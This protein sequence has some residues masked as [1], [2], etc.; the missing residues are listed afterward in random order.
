M[1]GIHEMSAVRVDDDAPVHVTRNTRA[2]LTFSEPRWLRVAALFAAAAV[3]SFGAVGL[4]L[5]LLGAYRPVLAFPLGSVAWIALLI[6]AW[7]Y[8]VEVSP[9]ATID[10]TPVA[11]VSH[12]AAVV[13]VLAILTITAWNAAQPSQHVLIT[14]DPGGYM[15]EGRWLARHG[16]LD[17]HPRVE[18]FA[19]EPELSY[20]SF[21]VYMMSDGTLQYQF[22]HLLPAVLAQTYA[23]GG[24]RLMFRA[25]ALLGGSAMLAFFVLAW[26]LLRR[27]WFAVGATVTLALLLPQVWFS[28]DSYSEI[29]SQVLLFTGLWLVTNDRILPAPRA[30]FAA[31]LFVGGLQMVRIDAMAFLVGAPVLLAVVWLTRAREQAAGN[32]DAARRIGAFVLGI[33]PGATLGIWDVTRHSGQYYRHLSSQMNG[34]IAATAG[35]A[36]V[37]LAV[38]ALWQRLGSTVRRIPTRFVAVSAGAGVAVIGLF[39]WAFRPSLQDTRGEVLGAIKALELR[40]HVGGDGT[41]RYYERSLTWMQWYLGWPTLAFAIAGAGLL[42]AALL[43]GRRPRALAATALLAP[44]SLLY[45]WKASAAPDHIWVARRFLT[46]AFPA[47]VLLAFGVAAFLFTRTGRAPS[48]I[49]AKVVAVTF[50]IAAIAYPVNALRSVRAMAEERGFLAVVND[51]CNKLGGEDAAVVVVHDGAGDLFF[52]WAPQTLRGWCG[53]QVAVARAAPDPA[54]LQRVADG[55]ATRGKHLYVVGVREDALRAAVPGAPIMRTVRAVN[56][57]DLDI[58]LTRRPDG[59]MTPSLQILIARV[60]TRAGT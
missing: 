58:T 46:S 22:A 6:L 53:A 13:G 2:T 1:H 54:M 34:L 12:L 26:R 3:L 38:V 56:G 11:R 16:S 27:P 24:D 5:A 25:P 30:A 29:P 35:S 37:S 17:A 31:G 41:R 39:A 55:W 45:L 32:K 8:L 36:I 4:L 23:V 48:T 47:F 14:R 21:S 59:Y 43:L 57:H 40:E 10:T 9:D 7:P 52:Q 19:A 33:L 28:R 44:T 51:A 42:T 20:N 15:N 50:A 60:P 18:P 49:V